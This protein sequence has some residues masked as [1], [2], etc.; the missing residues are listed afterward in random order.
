V[1]R[2]PLLAALLGAVLLGAAPARADDAAQREARALFG[3]GNQQLQDGDYVGALD[4]FRAAYARFPSVKILLN[5]GTTLRQLGRFAE[6]ADAYEAYL[7]DPAADPAKKAELTKQLADLDGRV[8]R[9][10]VTVEG[11]AAQVRVDGKVVGKPGEVVAVR[12][13][14]G[15][16]V[17]SADRE[18]ASPVSQNVTAVAGRQASVTLAVGAPRPDAPPTAKPADPSPIAPPPPDRDA[19]A[20]VPPPTLSHRGQLGA[21]LRADIDGLRAGVVPALGLAYGIGDYVEINTTALVGQ[22]KG[23]E[24]GATVL[25]LRGAWKPRLSVGVPIFFTDGVH[26][27]V[28]GGAGVEWDPI[29]YFG[30]FAE[31]GVSAFPNAPAGVDKVVFVPSVGVEPRIF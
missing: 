14:P 28:H 26:P 9:L 31:V 2:S 10:R 20:P 21:V 24:P 1:R 15:P 29:R 25:F 6:A 18:G 3:A 8:G 27:G 13:E 7:R 30:V 5:I 17:I 4:L 11:G 16:H 22:S 19:P 12:L 23:V